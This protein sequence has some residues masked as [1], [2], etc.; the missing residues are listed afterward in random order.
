MP[1]VATF[2]TFLLAPKY[3]FMF[4]VFNVLQIKF[5]NTTYQWNG[6]ILAACS[7]TSWLTTAA[8]FIAH[9]WTTNRAA[10]QMNVNL[11]TNGWIVCLWVCIVSIFKSFIIKWS[12]NRLLTVLYQQWTYKKARSPVGAVAA[13][14]QV[15]HG[16]SGHQG[17]AA[18]C[19]MRREQRGDVPYTH[20]DSRTYP[21]SL[22]A[23][24][25]RR[26]MHACIHTDYLSICKLTFIYTY[27]FKDYG[28]PSLDG[29]G[30]SLRNKAHSTH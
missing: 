3:F 19:A 11:F 18:D 28:C 22:S 7:L 26:D 8:D 12:F 17:Y 30:W 16:D 25:F 20:T 21:L 9:W 10:S 15:E 1:V 4:S 23:A 6:F 2:V 24:S 27:D 29:W 14:W 13:V 5:F